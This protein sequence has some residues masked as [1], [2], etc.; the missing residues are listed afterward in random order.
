MQQATVVSFLLTLGT[1]VS[2]Q[3][4][5]TALFV[6]SDFIINQYGD[7]DVSLELRVQA[8]VIR[9]AVI[10]VVCNRQRILPRVTGAGTRARPRKLHIVKLTDV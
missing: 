6:L 10:G 2:A 9:D 3:P 7:R 8:T 5:C 1:S 4:N